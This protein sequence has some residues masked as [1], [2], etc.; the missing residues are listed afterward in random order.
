MYPASPRPSLVR[1][2]TAFARD[3][4]VGVMVA[5]VLLAAATAGLA[6]RTSG[7]RAE[8]LPVA[9]VH[10]GTT[11]PTASVVPKVSLRNG[12]AQLWISLDKV[13]TQDVTVRAV[14]G[15]AVAEIVVPAGQRAAAVTIQRPQ[16][17]LNVRLTSY[18]VMTRN[19]VASL[20]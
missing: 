2:L 13:D 15:S 6:T 8:P 7:A 4:W 19:G 10:G 11:L 1:R 20:P 3:P 12:V 5:V 14:V 17:P 16:G 18:D 9:A